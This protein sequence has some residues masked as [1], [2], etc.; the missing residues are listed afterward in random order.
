MEILILCIL[1]GL[2]FILALFSMK[3]LQFPHDIRDFFTRRRMKGKIV[4]FEG[5]KVKH[6]SSSSSSRSSV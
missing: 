6:Y 5:K 2:S 4:F 1:A 3:D